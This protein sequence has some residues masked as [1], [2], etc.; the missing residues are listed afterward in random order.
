[1]AAEDIR[2]TEVEAEIRDT[3]MEARIAEISN[4]ETIEV[5][6]ETEINDD[7]IGAIAGIAAREIEGVASLGAN[8]IRRTIS[9][10]V[11]GGER[12]SRG[13]EVEAGRRE[14]ILDIDLRVIYGFSVPEIVIKVRQNVARRVLEMCGLVTKEIN[15]NVTSIEFAEKLPTRVE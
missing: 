10:R 6:G 15:I 8:S 1:M 2:D 7:V 4:L 9:E 14:A 5:V 12:Q 3:E 11:G 13:V